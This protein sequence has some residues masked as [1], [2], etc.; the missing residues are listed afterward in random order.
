MRCN[1]TFLVMSCHWHWCWHH[2]MPSALLK[3]TLHSLH[4]DNQNQEQQDYFVHMTQLQLPLA[5]HD[6]TCVGVKWWHWDKCQS[7]MMLTTSEIASLHF[8]GQGDRSEVQHDFLVHMMPLGLASASCDAKSID[9]DNTALLRSRW[10]KWSA[11]WLFGYV[12]PASTLHHADSIVNS[13]ITFL[14]STW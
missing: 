3:E 2:M 11:T 5:S 13:N 1:G 6:A 7:Y 4:E 12:T 8:L 9:N 10:S 14:M